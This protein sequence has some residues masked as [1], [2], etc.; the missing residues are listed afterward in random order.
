[1]RPISVC[2]MCANFDTHTHTKTLS[3]TLRTLVFIA[4]LCGALAAAGL[5]IIFVSISMQI[6]VDFVC[7]NK[8]PIEYPD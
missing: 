6:D 5:F 3:R 2:K 1:M 4:Q 8:T 7:T